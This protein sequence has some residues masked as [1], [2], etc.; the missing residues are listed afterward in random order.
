L[1]VLNAIDNK[2]TFTL[3]NSTGK[4]SINS[5]FTFSVLS[6]STILKLIGGDLNTLYNALPLNKKRITAEACIHH[7]WFS[8][9]DYEKKGNWIKWN[10]AIKT[11]ADRE[12]I[13]QAV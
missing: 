13:F 1:D 7:L 11:A 8:D 4:Y 12:A 5:N 3:N 9:A 2:I 6:S 10:P